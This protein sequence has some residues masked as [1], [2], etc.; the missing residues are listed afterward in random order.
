MGLTDL[1]ARNESL[2]PREGG[3]RLED[4]LLALPSSNSLE[5]EGIRKVPVFG[6]EKPGMPY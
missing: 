1:E 4:G 3:E 6:Q 2:Y 5:L